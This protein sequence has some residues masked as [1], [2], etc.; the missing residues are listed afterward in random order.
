MFF[1]SGYHETDNVSNF[2]GT[3]QEGDLGQWFCSGF[4]LTTQLGVPNCVLLDGGLTLLKSQLGFKEGTNILPKFYEEQ[5]AKVLRLVAKAMPDF[6]LRV[7]LYDFEGN[8]W[9]MA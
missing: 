9:E 3:C 1:V 2:W 8:F 7:V 4:P 6:H 5:Q